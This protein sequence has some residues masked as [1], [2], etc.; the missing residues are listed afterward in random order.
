[1]T[2]R[3]DY[4]DCLSIHRPIHAQYVTDTF[5]FYKQDVL[6]GASL[7][8]MAQTYVAA[9]NGGAVPAIA[10]AWQSVAEGECRKAG[11]L[12]SEAWASVF[13]PGV[14]ACGADELSITQAHER[15]VRSA[16]AAFDANAVGGFLSGPRTAARAAMTQNLDKRRREYVTKRFAEAAALCASRL[17]QAGVRVRAVADAP[18]ATVADV[19]AAADAEAAAIDA[20]AT[21]LG[22]GRHEQLT[23]WLRDIAESTVGGLARL[24][25]ERLTRELRVATERAA[26]ETCAAQA[27]A[28]RVAVS[29]KR[30]DDALHR[31]TACAERASAA[32]RDAADANARAAAVSCNAEAKLSIRDAELSS[33]KR[34][35]ERAHAE[36]AQLKQALELE[37]SRCREVS[38]HRTAAER[39]VVE[40]KRDGAAARANGV[41]AA[42]AIGTDLQKTKA[43]LAHAERSLEHAQSAAADATARASLEVSQARAVA[44]TGVAAAEA[45]AAEAKRSASDAEKRAKIAETEVERLKGGKHYA[46]G[47]TDQGD[48]EFHDAGARD[49]DETLERW[50]DEAAAAAAAVAP[51]AAADLG[52]PGK[53]RRDDAH[54][55][56]G[57]GGTRAGGVT[58]GDR[59]RARVVDGVDAVEAAAGEDAEET[60]EADAKKRQEAESMTVA[61]LKHEL[62]VMGLAHLYVGQRGIK[63]GDLVGM[64]VNG[65]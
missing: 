63:K 28:E 17:A 57:M 32:T 34:D 40:L 65:D 6:N 11:A 39:E 22:P 38:E 31:V 4:S 43:Q 7:A 23:H 27:A 15:A 8:G 20:D 50:R 47:N 21:T 49:D 59:T 33:A 18:D 10:T 53:R 51:V 12:G 41:A 5:L 3:T 46:D 37:K 13:F 2:V 42:S 36:V 48:D 61:Q 35:T 30:A 26:R 19:V 55:G 58:A 29:E 24:A 9:I 64:F 44:A 14:D 54:T 56:G 16:G 62:Q 1:M 25:A 60:C 52:S 45:A